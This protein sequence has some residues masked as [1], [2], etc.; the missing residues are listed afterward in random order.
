MRKWIGTGSPGYFCCAKSLFW[1][2]SFQF[3]VNVELIFTKNMYRNSYFYTCFK[4]ILIRNSLTGKTS[5][6][7]FFP[8]QVGTL[9]LTRT[10]L[11]ERGEWFS[12]SSS[13]PDKK[14]I[15]LIFFYS[16]ASSNI[17]VNS[18]KTFKAQHLLEKM[19]HPQ[20]GVRHR[21]LRKR[22]VATSDQVDCLVLS[23]SIALSAWSQSAVQYTSY[24]TN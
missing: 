1:N 3:L 24:K 9:C 10:S 20:K 2:S 11:G 7:S 16:S 13:F 8:G 5:H 15:S 4:N 19:W 23:P 21:T 18:P 22:S 14:T 17:L 12:Y 6:F